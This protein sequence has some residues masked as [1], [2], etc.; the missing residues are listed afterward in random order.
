MLSINCTPTNPTPAPTHHDTPPRASRHI[1][2]CIMFPPPAPHEATSIPFRGGGGVNG[3]RWAV[4]AISRYFSHRRGNTVS[5][6]YQT[7]NASSHPLSPAIA[8][9]PLASSH[10]LS[11]LAHSPVLTRSPSPTRS[12]LTCSLLTCSL[13]TTNLTCSPA[14]YS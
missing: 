1:A 5:L 2:S 4:N 8:S 10:P 6:H 12:L 3:E 13:L 9:R 14:H 11:P 7:L